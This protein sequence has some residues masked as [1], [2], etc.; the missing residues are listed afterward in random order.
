MENDSGS[1]SED[2]ILANLC[3]KNQQNAQFLH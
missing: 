1:Q 2:I 3:N